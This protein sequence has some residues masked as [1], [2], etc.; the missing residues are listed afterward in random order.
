[1]MRLH[2]DGRI[3]LCAR[4]GKYWTGTASGHCTFCTAELAPIDWPKVAYWAAV[5]V[6]G[7]AALS[8][9]GW[10]LVSP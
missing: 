7:I 2:S 5:F 1:M 4:C 6:I 8:M 3:H 9:A 10:A